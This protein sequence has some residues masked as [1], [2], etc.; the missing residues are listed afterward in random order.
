MKK[1]LLS[2]LILS[3][4]TACQEDE[5]GLPSVEDR[6]S[7]AVEALREDLM[8]PANGWKVFYQPTTTSGSFFMIMKFKD[9]G[10]VT[11]ST[12]LAANAG[13]FHEQT[14]PYRIDAGQG[15]ELIF[16]T[17]GA[18]HYLFELDQASFGAEFEFVYEE[19]DDGD[20]Y[21]RSKSDLNDPTSIVFSE[22]NATDQSAFSREIAANFDLYAGQS[23][24]LFGGASPTQ[25]LY[26]SD[27][28]IS[29]FWSINLA[30]RMVLFDLAGSGSSLEEVL[31]G[32][33]VSLNQS[34]GYTFLDGK[35]IFNDPV[36]FNVGAKSVELSELT[37]GDF[38]ETGSPLC[39]TSAVNTPVYTVAG[40][41]TLTK[42]LFNSSGLGF[43][44]QA[45]SLYSVNI[46]FIFDDSLRSLAEEGSI[47]QKLPNA[48]A[49]IMTY[50]FESDSIPANAAGFL[51]E[52]E[53]ENSSFYLRSFTP[54]AVGNRLE[55]E[56]QDEYYYSTTTTPEEEAALTEI[57][58]EVFE[59]GSV[60]AYDLPIRGLTVFQFYNPCN[61]YEFVLVK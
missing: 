45:G 17:Y 13:E 56:W 14:I 48:I 53:D 4:F 5:K 28:D 10:T 49:F 23:P 21:F 15:L 38:S 9:D 39:E 52:D 16:E 7:T 36:Q 2:L 26:L 46:P 35:I 47:K 61:G 59:G 12:D 50:G 11:I 43:E 31:S 54:T 58:D 41:G 37:L 40:G 27:L 25:Q 32:T 57:L 30:K 3:L 19:K 29:V 20:L 22:A 55:M 33:S 6:V 44:P 18:L 1:I 34:S 42:N 8:D 24:R 60:Y 51:V